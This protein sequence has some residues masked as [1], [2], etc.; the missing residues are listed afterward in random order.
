MQQADFLKEN[1]GKGKPAGPGIAGVIFHAFFFSVL[2]LLFSH[3]ARAQDTKWN[4]YDSLGIVPPFK[5]Y[6]L[7]GETFTP[8]SLKK[9]KHRT[10]IIYFKTGCEYCLN[11]FKIIKHS[12]SDFPDTQF[13][14]VSWEDAPALKTY[15]S[16]RQFRY[17]PQIRILSDKD[18]LYRTWFEVHYT[19]SVHIYDE[20]LKLLH[21]HDGMINREKLLSFLK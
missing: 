9:G 12:M 8:D 19:P 1:G 13:I 2:F 7:K 15:D 10:V 11:E 5:F 18:G 14:L 21:F 17:F 3:T 16:L 20:Q 6:N 4:H